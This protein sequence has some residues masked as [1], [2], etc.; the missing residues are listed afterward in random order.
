M[1]RLNKREDKNSIPL[2]NFYKKKIE[3]LS[4]KDKKEKSRKIN[5]FL[6]ELP[7]LKESPNNFAFY[8]ALKQEPCLFET[9]SQFKDRACFPVIEG[10]KLEFY[11][12]PE[13]QWKKGA[14]QIEEPLKI[15]ENKVSL[16]DISLFFIPGSCFDHQGF[17]FGKG[18]GYYDKTLS[19]I[20][21]DD[22]KNSFDF[23]NQTLFIGTAFLE[24]VQKSPLPVKAHDIRL[25]FLVTDQFVL[26]PLNKARSKKNKE[27][28]VLKS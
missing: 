23:K 24:Q 8:K 27:E 5:H 18:F 25:N 6:A 13:N 12:N 16:K 20:K 14:F 19:Q 9:Y 15:K 26:C 11:T 4:E 2:R 10:E 7:F 22:S 28:A 21:T 1:E 17:R 3:K